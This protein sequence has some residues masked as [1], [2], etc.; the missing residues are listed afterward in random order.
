MSEPL[1]KV[2]MLKTIPSTHKTLADTLKTLCKLRQEQQTFSKRND[3]G[4]TR[5]ISQQ[6]K[7]RDAQD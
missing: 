2:T 6:V 3:T 1:P 7:A 5:R 4:R